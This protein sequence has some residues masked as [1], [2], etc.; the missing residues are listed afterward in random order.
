MVGLLMCLPGAAGL[1]MG[2]VLRE[3]R[4]VNLPLWTGLLFLV[5]GLGYVVWGTLRLRSLR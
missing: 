2:F 3:H 1:G 5:G 4:G